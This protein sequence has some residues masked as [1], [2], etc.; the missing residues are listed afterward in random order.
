MTV[1]LKTW[2]GK[3]GLPGIKAYHHLYVFRDDPGRQF[4]R[5]DITDTKWRC[6]GT[7]EAPPTTGSVPCITGETAVGGTGRVACGG[8]FQPVMDNMTGYRNNPDFVACRAGGPPDVSA[9][10][11]PDRSGTET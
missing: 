4:T 7:H 5:R 8:Y 2:T 10:L 6:G 9:P 1:S 11:R 3:A